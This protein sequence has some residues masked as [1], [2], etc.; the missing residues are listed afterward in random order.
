MLTKEKIS[1]ILVAWALVAM[2]VATPSSIT[3]ASSTE[4]DT[5][6][7][8][9][10]SGGGD[11][12]DESPPPTDNEE[13]TVTPNNNDE[14][15]VQ[16]DEPPPTDIPEQTLTPTEQEDST[17]TCPDGTEV[18]DMKDCPTELPAPTIPIEN[19]ELPEEC[20]PGTTALECLNDMLGTEPDCGDMTPLECL[21]DKLNKEEPTIED[22]KPNPY[23]DKVSDEYMQNGGFCHD[24]LDFDEETGLFPCNDGTQQKDWRDCDDATELPNGDHPSHDY[25]QALGCPGSPPDPEK[26]CNDGRDPVEGKCPLPP[27]DHKD[28][29]PWGKYDCD[30]PRHDKHKDGRDHD[31]NFH[32]TIIKKI[33]IHKTINNEDDFPDV[34]IVGL[35]IKDSGA[36]MICMMNINND[37]I[38]C[39]DFGVPNDRINDDIWRIIEVNSDENFDDADTGSDDVDDAIDAV[40]QQDFTELNDLDNHNFNV[41]L[42][43]LGINPNG[44]GLLCLIEDSSDEG[45]AVCER[46]SVNSEAISGQITETT[47]ISG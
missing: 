26:G 24:R 14:S 2:M 29:K 32:R 10:G 4:D 27:R 34:D 38:E 21:N 36:A 30:R 40:S 42:A 46:F 25:C 3:F 1:L 20:A 6:S 19:G 9:E 13:G 16:T 11:A 43:A 37:W 17:V 23:C 41:D 28:C 35:S 47:E 15:P 7:G 39:Q 8:D 44:D 33:D 31:D 45:S 5:S 12:G 18:I 22:N